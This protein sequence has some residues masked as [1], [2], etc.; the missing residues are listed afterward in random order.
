MTGRPDRAAASFI[1]FAMLKTVELAPAS[2]D[3]LSSSPVESSCRNIS[4]SG[5]SW[6]FRLIN[7]YFCK[8]S[9]ATGG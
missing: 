8:K 1:H 5:G 9:C 3:T 2:F 4:L 7:V 6:V